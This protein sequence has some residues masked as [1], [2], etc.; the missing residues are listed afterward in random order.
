MS[1]DLEFA[2]WRRL[3]E[4]SDAG[5]VVALREEAMALGMRDTARAIGRL[6]PEDQ[7]RILT[8]FDPERAAEL[9]Q[10]ISD[11][12]AAELV[13]RLSAEAAAPILEQMDSNEAADLLTALEPDH[14]S[15]ILAIMDPE[16]AEDARLL[17]A[18]NPDEAGGLMITEYLAY[19][20]HY[21]TR[22][23]IDDFRDNVEEYRGYPVQYTYVVDDQERLIGVL[24]L[25]NLLLSFGNTPISS[26]MIPNPL[27]V[28]DH[29]HLDGLSEFFEEHNF[30][31][32][33]VTDSAGVLKGVI[34]REAVEEA[35]GERAESHYLKSQGIIGGDEL[36]SMPMFKRARRRLSWLCANIGLTIIAASVIALYQD[37]LAAVI[38]LTVFLP[39]ISGLSGNAGIQAVAVSMRE[40][41]LGL[42][43]P[44][45]LFYVL[46]K[47]LTIG[48][49][50]GLVLGALIAVAA[51]VWQGNPWLGAVVGIAMV[52]N[53]IIAVAVGGTVPL[54]LKRFSIDP[55][56]A[57]GPI[58]TTITDMCGFFLVLSLAA[59]AIHLLT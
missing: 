6:D 43:K 52:L 37:T 38:A 28:H 56:L 9:V 11:A 10:E 40:L 54:V 17:S 35:Q 15:D 1:T 26:V 23:V 48:L 33:P 14:A 42:I 3:E 53:T 59:A 5:D 25:R 57:S 45:D 34:T 49:I 51:W 21:I 29:D 39:I 2:P 12:Q 47:E 50:N 36:R 58:L 24:P 19:P 30:L 31:A 7:S 16:T 18:Y 46:Q 55:A 20:E 32:A 13:S 44:I 8:L 41:T 4:L 22:Q 27:R